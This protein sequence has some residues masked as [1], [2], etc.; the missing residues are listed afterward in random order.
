MNT[1]D[2]MFS[3]RNPRTPRQN[4]GQNE[5]MK[6]FKDSV[7]L[8]CSLFFILLFLVGLIYIICF[9]YLKIDIFKVFTSKDAGF[10]NDS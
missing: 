2:G 8:C 1:E 9:Y 5:T 7:I 3:P 10:D 4:K 6:K